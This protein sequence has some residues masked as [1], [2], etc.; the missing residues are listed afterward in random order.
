MN[1]KNWLIVVSVLL[2][3]AQLWIFE[4]NFTLLQL[5]LKTY[6]FIIETTDVQHPNFGQFNKSKIA[7]FNKNFKF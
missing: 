2:F 6:L 1:S 7:L 3:L 5:R 4:T